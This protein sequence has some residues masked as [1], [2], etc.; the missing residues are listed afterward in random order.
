M[1]FTYYF[2]AVLPEDDPVPDKDKGRLVGKHERGYEGILVPVEEAIERLSGGSGRRGRREDSLV[3]VADEDKIPKVSELIRSG[4]VWKEGGPGG[5]WEDEDEDVP[6][7]ESDNVEGGEKDVWKSDTVEAGEK[8]VWK[9]GPVGR[10]SDTI[11]IGKDT[12]DRLAAEGK[13]RFVP[14][15]VNGGDDK[16]VQ[17]RVVYEGWKRLQEVY[18]RKRREG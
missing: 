12:A 11:R 13:G 17:A 2:L 14:C 6:A 4:K 1:Y 15:P 3:F 10:E 7:W 18:G 16:T 9:A 5:E 8:D